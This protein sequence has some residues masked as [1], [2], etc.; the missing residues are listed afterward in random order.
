MYDT[1]VPG[2]R[3]ILIVKLSALGDVA[4][5]LPVVDFLRNAAPGADVPPDRL[6][7]NPRSQHF[8][9]DLLQRITAESLFGVRHVDGFSDH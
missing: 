2:Y 7:V 8:D 6:A 3:R 1:P 5:A 9:A 4:H